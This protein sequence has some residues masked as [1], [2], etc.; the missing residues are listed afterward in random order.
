[1]RKDSAGAGTTEM[2]DTSPA[3]PLDGIR[4]VGALQPPAYRGAPLRGLHG[5]LDRLHPP[6]LQLPLLQAAPP[7]TP[8]DQDG[9]VGPHLLI[10]VEL[11]AG[12]GGWLPLCPHGWS[13]LYY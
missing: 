5:H 1:M 12:D 4:S 6:L 8:H 7:K 10:R 11:L 3:F 9:A 2:L 13:S